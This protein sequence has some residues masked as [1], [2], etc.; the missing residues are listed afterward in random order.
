LW[1]RT[2]FEVKPGVAP[3][4]VAEVAPLGHDERLDRSGFARD[5]DGLTGRV[6]STFELTRLLTGEMAVGYQVRRYD[7]PRLRDLRGPVLDGTLVWTPTPLTTVRFKASS[8]LDETIVVGGN[9]TQ[10]QTVGIEVEHALQR[11]WTL[12]GAATFSHSDYRGLSTTENGFAASLKIDY[13]LTR[14]LV[15]RGSYAHERLDSTNAGSDYK[16]NIVML[17]LRL[18]R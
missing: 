11:N 6:G 3:L 18:Q 4:V 13:K 1:L 16:A 7:D 8:R 9:G 14:E 17:G 5:S 2:G 12:I 10:A 15:L